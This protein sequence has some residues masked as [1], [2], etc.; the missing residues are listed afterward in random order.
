MTK[1]LWPNRL[2]LKNS[3]YLMTE[4]L[5]SMGL[6]GLEPTTSRLKARYCYQLSY[7]PEG[8]NCQGAKCVVSLDHLLRIPQNPLRGKWFVPVPKVDL[9][10]WGLVPPPTQVLYRE[11]DPNG[12]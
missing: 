5:R 8:L 9:A 2:G 7:R 6:V 1:S 3:L 12:K 4:L 11:L 10:V